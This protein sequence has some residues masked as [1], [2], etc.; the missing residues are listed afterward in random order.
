MQ[1]HGWHGAWRGL[2]AAGL[3]LLAALPA[4]AFAPAAGD[5]P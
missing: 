3:A 2:A 5:A 4:R 1:R